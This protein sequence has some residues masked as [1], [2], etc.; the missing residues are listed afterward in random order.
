MAASAPRDPNDRRWRGFVAASAR[1]AG[2]AEPADV[3]AAILD[4]VITLLDLEAASIGLIDPTGTRV[5]FVLSRGPAKLDEFEVEVGVGIAGWVAKTGEGLVVNDV[6]RDPRFFKGIDESSGFQTRAILCAPL[7]HE[8]RILGI[9]EAINPNRRDAFTEADLELLTAFGAVAASAMERARAVSALRGSN[10]EL[11]AAASERYKLVLGPSRAM[12]AVLDLAS[13]AAGSS[14]TVLLLGESGT[15]KEVV[16]RAIHHWSTR[17]KGPFV[18]VNCTALSTELLESEL[19]GHERGSFTGAVAQRKGRFELADGGTLFLDEIGELAPS[20]QAKLLRVLQDREFQRVGG[21][22]TIRVDVRIVAATNR[23]LRVAVRERTFRED[24][25]YRLNVITIDL[26]ALRERLEDVPGLVE[27]FVEHFCREMGRPLLQVA[28]ETLACLRAYP[29]P[30]NVRELQN[31][32]ERAI[33][34]TRGATIRVADLPRDIREPDVGAAHAGNGANDVPDELDLRE[35][36]DVF[37]RL[38][39]TRALAAAGGSQ[40]DAARRLGLP[41]S[42]LSRLMKRLGLR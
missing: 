26:P 42:N 2:D 37:T 4:A 41:Q 20:L 21:E 1:L 31:A 38:R 35:A 29:W 25:Y 23:D 5:R 6:A 36:I 34:L 12:R 16:G 24:L 17:E 18:A 30:G 19:F 32:V 3:F 13:T 39:V 40:T 28:D 33:V 27:H 8:E 11:R 9:I 7:A 15:G 22:K 10:A 14:S